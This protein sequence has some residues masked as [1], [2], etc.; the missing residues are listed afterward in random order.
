[1]INAPQVRDNLRLAAAKALGEQSVKDR[2][3]SMGA[4]DFSFYQQHK[5]GAM[6]NIGIAQDMNNIIPLHNGKLIIDENA[7][8]IAPKVFV[9]YILN[10]CE[11]EDI[12]Y[13][14]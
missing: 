3:V 7:L 5:P 13:G 12:S 9:Q 4:E 1:M 6:F 14:L 8:D 2:P 11:R 10:A